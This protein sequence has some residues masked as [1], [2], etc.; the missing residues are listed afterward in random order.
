MRGNKDSAA[1]A[2]PAVN[3]AQWAREMVAD[4]TCQDRVDLKAFKGRGSTYALRHLID[5]LEATEASMLALSA[6]SRA[7]PGGNVYLMVHRRTSSVSVP[8]THLSEWMTS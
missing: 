6:A 5:R 8:R 1:G 2:K 7:L 4:P 3:E